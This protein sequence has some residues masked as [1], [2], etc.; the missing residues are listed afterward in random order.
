LAFVKCLFGL[1]SDV[2]LKQLANTYEL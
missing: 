2:A 1:Q